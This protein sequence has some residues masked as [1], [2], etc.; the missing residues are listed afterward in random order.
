MRR[1]ILGL[2]LALLTHSSFAAAPSIPLHDL[3]GQP[4]NVNEFV[5]QGKWVIAE[6][7]CTFGVRPDPEPSEPS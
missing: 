4:R 7:F 6:H 5:G 2:A 1:F 3:D